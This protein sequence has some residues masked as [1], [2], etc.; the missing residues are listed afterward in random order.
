MAHFLLYSYAAAGASSTQY[1]VALTS[2]AQRPSLDNVA[3]TSA[4]SFA[5]NPAFVPEYDGTSAGLI[6]RVQHD[7]AAVPAKC[8]G[9]H[10]PCTVSSLAFVAYD[11]THPSR[12][13]PLGG[14]AAVVLAPSG[15]A[16]E[17][18]VQDPRLIIDPA[19]KQFVM[20][21]TSI[22]GASPS[23]KPPADRRQGIATSKTPSVRG[24][25]TRHCDGPALCVGAEGVK[26]GAML[27]RTSP[28]HYLFLYDL[29]E[30]KREIVVA[31]KHTAT[32][33]GW[34]DWTLLNQT[35]IA[36]RPGMW[37]A[38]LIEPGPPPLLLASGDYLM[39]YNS[40]EEEND[41]GYHVGWVIL[42]GADPTK[43][44]QRSKSPLLSWTNR[45]WSAGNDTN[46]L[47]NVPEVVFLAAARPLPAAAAAAAGVSTDVTTGGEEAF[48]LFFGAADAVVGRA[49]IGVVT[50]GA[51]QSTTCSGV[52]G[53][54][55]CGFVGI[56]QSG[57]EQ[58]GC[59]WV[60]APG[61]SDP[62]CFYKQGPAPAPTPTGRSC[63]VLGSAIAEPFTM[64]EIGQ[65]TDL[66]EANVNINGSGAI[67]AAPDRNT[68]PGGSYY[69]HWERDGA[70]TM[71][72]RQVNN[73]TTPTELRAYSK[74]VAA[75]Q[76]MADT[77][78]IDVR[79]EPKYMIPDGSIFDGA[80]CR[81]QNDGPGLRATALIIYADALLDSGAAEDSSYV[82][83]T[84]WRSDGTGTI[85]TSLAYLTDGGWSSTTCDLWEEVRSD[86]FFWN[87]VSM[88]RA[89]NAGAAF[90]TKQGDVASA[91][92]YSAL[93]Q[94][95]GSYIISGH[96]D[97][98]SGY[99]FEQISRRMD[100]AVIVGLNFQ[101]DDPASPTFTP[102][103]LAV[104]Q[105]ISSYNTAFCAEY[106]IN[107]EGT[108]GKLPG[109]L[110]G[111]Y[112]GDT[113]DGGNPWILTT[114][115]LAQLLYRVAASCSETLPNAAALGVWASTL[116]APSLA[117][118]PTAKEA[119]ATFTIAG[120]SVL[121]RI[122]HYVRD[123]NIGMRMDEQIEK[124][125]GVMTSAKSLT[126]SYAEIFNALQ[127]RKKALGGGK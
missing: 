111:R 99:I 92:K 72:S 114:A 10:A 2:Q 1:S 103:S 17:T 50:T 123:A 64:S 125:T 53:K 76:T 73:L 16:F 124:H 5:Y 3:G 65:M 63:F 106:P 24:S 112:P 117:A 32:S 19:T 69:Y 49:T 66:F 120:D 97:T 61:T 30:K 68:G 12:L 122:A 42:S 39:L 82:A 78:Q 116:N 18:D 126:W 87:R 14:A 113:Y 29:R 95:I 102:Q 96:V 119:A 118:A 7:S 62:W 9:N 100:G 101:F 59:C 83:S 11:A 36:K 45:T 6:V 41:R 43:V 35:L 33:A 89:L 25:W 40:A 8:V 44:L 34:T 23:V 94:K 67:V 13:A 115:A 79:T 80:W 21:Y 104:A 46:A 37:D 86:D 52:T 91:A 54:T 47:C 48:E 81:P 51:A 60:P 75:R 93:A 58:K 70:L 31:V 110:Y 26:S 4:W 38:G 105:T 98:Q 121:S 84:L 20:T 107:T 28:P 88:K 27:L 71:T 57:C 127:W 85:Q 77:H 15:S 109:I 108:G 22:G 56:D 74:W 55:D 90:A